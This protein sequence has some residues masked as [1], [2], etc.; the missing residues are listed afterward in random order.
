MRRLALVACLLALPGAAGCGGVD[1]D[2]ARR[3]ARTYVAR[4]GRR[5]GPGTC[6]QM[7]KALQR[8]FLEAVARS[9]A[10]FRGRTCGQVMQVALAA[11]PPADLRRFAH[12]K[13]SD[14]EVKGDTGTF[15]YSLATIRVDGRVAKEGGTWKVSCCVPG[16]GGG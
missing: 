8:Q 5:D 3:A 7:T 13:I 11:I 10:R 12:A 9:D 15:R 2:G 16:A 14:L 4:L 6:A 1:T